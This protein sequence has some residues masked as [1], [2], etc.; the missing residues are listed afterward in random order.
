MKVISPIDCY[1]PLPTAEDL[2]GGKTFFDEI[3]NAELYASGRNA[4]GS[5]IAQIKGSDAKNMWLPKLICPSMPIFFKEFFEVNFYDENKIEELKIPATDAILFL[6]FFGA[7][8]SEVIENW[9]LENPQ[10][11]SILDAT[12]APFSN[13]AKST[14]A[15]CVFA[16]LRK[17][18]PIPDGAYLKLKNQT[19]RKI[20]TSPTNTLPDFFSDILSAMTL[21]T[22]A[23]KSSCFDEKLYR[24]LFMRGEE[25]LFKTKTISRMSCYSFEVL[26]SLNVDKILKMRKIQILD[27]ENLSEIKNLTCEKIVP[28]DDT[29]A[30]APA[31]VVNDEATFEKLRKMFTTQHNRPCSYWNKP[32]FTF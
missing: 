26:K 20:A 27:F 10:N 28:R 25:K 21:K 31:L 6:D 11:F 14:N 1:L 22:L 19:P 4:L 5:I 8:N 30:F 18:L 2:G 23:L 13:W 17:L 9:I 12:F 29:S 3:K 15:S 16:S 7:T 32:D 24:K